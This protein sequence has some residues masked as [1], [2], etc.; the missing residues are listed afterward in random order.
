MTEKENKELKVIE[1][2]EETSPF[3]YFYSTGCAFCKQLDPIIDELNKEGHDIL[4]LDALEP[5]NKKIVEKLTKE[6]D[7]K[8][9][10]PWLIN[11]ETGHQICG[12]RERDAVEKWLAGESIPTQP[13]P[14]RQPP[15]PPFI[16]SSKKEETKWKKEYEKWVEENSHLPNTPTAEE[17]LKKPRPKT[18]PPKPPNPSM[19]D[20]QLDEWGKEYD[21]W[22]NKNKHLPNLQPV[23]TI[24]KRFKQQK[25]KMQ[26]QQQ[27]N[28]SQNLNSNQEARL[29][30]LEQKI[31][32]LMKHLGVK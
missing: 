3:Y 11:I 15:K 2:L 5:E 24:L 27:Q 9:G 30:R 28:N 10:T 26:Q 32:K 14:T 25:N 21:V 6:Y 7:V 8:C 16:G 31:D 19:T 13:I 23:E 29:S 18:E 12:W 1:S 20:K 22:K 17:I 4:K